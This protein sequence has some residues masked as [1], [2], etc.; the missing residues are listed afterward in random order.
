MEFDKV[1]WNIFEKH[2]FIEAYV[3]YKNFKE[4]KLDPMELYKMETT[5]PR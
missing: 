1:F 3:N 5:K 4:N 2:G